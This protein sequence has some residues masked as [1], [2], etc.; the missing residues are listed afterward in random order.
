MERR[1]MDIW[2][3]WGNQKEK[4]HYEDPDIGGSIILRWI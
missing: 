1:R 4:D 2:F 3:Q